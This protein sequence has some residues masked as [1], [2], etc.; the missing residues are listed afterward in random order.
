MFHNISQ[1]NLFSRQI[2][3]YDMTKYV[4][5]FLH[6]RSKIILKQNSAT[7]ERYD[8]SLNV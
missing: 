8:E 3:I 5:C 6:F 1:Q 7:L 4:I 2:Y